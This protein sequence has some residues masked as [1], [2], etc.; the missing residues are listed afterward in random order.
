MVL[1][2]AQ[3]TALAAVTNKQSELDAAKAAYEQA[4]P[5]GALT[6]TL[7]RDKQALRDSFIDPKRAE[8]NAAVAD[9][10]EAGRALEA[11]LKVAEPSNEYTKTLQEKANELAKEQTQLTQKI[12]TQRRSF[13]DSSPQTGTGGAYGLSHDA[14]ETAMLI[15]FVGF[16]AAYIALFANFVPPSDYKIPIGIVGF[17]FAWAAVN[18]AI[19]YLG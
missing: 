14:D 5:Q 12:R 9:C 3:Q 15:L 4:D 17:L 8:A 18:R 2:A 10:I 7:T 19:L 16:V 13:L 1:T 11:L 6:A